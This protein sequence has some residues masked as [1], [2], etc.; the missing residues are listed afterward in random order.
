M[1][2]FPFYQ[3]LKQPRR[4]QVIAHRGMMRRAPENTKPALELAIEAGIEWVEVDVRLTGD[5]YHVL[6]HSSLLDKTTDGKGSVEEHTMAQIK[7]LD[8]GSWF[9]PRY[10]GERVLSLEECLDLAYRR[11]NLYL[12]CKRVNPRL[13]VGQI[14]RAGMQDQVVVFGKLEL[15]R[16]IRALSNGEIA[17]MPKWWPKYGLDAWLDDVQPNAVEINADVITP[18]ICRAFHGREIYVQAKT[19]GEWDHPDIW[20]KMLRAKVD[21]IQTDMPEE[22]ITY[23]LKTGG[24]K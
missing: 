22:L 18:E 11:I 19:L 4:F 23:G 1:G 16:Q 2:W 7:R 6:M 21:W 15:L 5:G 13:L 12:D 10:A 17:I 20:D 8:A 24:E 14:L 9:S 3:P